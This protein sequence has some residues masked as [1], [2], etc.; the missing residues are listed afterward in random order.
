MIP[1]EEQFSLD[2]LARCI[3]EAPVDLGVPAN[4]QVKSVLVPRDERWINHYTV[5]RAGDEDVG[6]L[7]EDFTADRIRLTKLTFANGAFTD[8]KALLKAL[9]SWSDSDVTGAFQPT[10]NGHHHS[11]SNRWSQYPCWTMDVHD[12]QPNLR[13]FSG[14]R[15]PFKKIEKKF[16]VEDL[17]AAVARWAGDPTSQDN[18]VRNSYR[19]ILLDQRAYFTKRTF[20]GH[21]L[22][23]AVSGTKKNKVACTLSTGRGEEPEWKEVTN[24]AV[25]FVVMGSPRHLEAFLIDESDG[26]CDRY[27]NPL[28]PKYA[29][30]TAFDS[31]FP[32]YE[33]GA[34]EVGGT[35][36]PGDA[37]ATEAL[38]GLH[39]EAVYSDWQRA[40][41]RRINDPAGAITLARTLLET[42][43]KHI[44][45]ERNVSYATTD[46][47]SD[48][49][50]KVL[51]E[52]GLAPSEQ[53]EQLFKQIFS[54]VT[55]VVAGLERLRNQVGDAHGRPKDSAKPLER[56][57][58]LAVNL[59]GT[60]AAFLA[61]AHE[62]DQTKP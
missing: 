1:P 52:L 51:S 41:E 43:C 12:N 55:S 3:C 29:V 6:T 40:L 24:G 49:H 39:S 37:P 38:Q 46:G 15:G 13:D 59:A 22:R 16:L 17:P 5:L 31:G 20:D 9:T 2:I 19:I 57:A 58:Q 47:L 21:K 48:L 11:S 23:L 45:D 56:D 34:E 27:W 10:V 30:A 28:E 8:G 61:A 35:A 60:V 62:A 54:G 44:L 36:F 53:T 26:W 7:K 4:V 42:T 33:P 50:R 32:I 25:E 14:P 18:T